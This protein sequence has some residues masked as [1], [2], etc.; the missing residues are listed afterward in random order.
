MKTRFDS[1]SKNST[2]VSRVRW[3]D[4]YFRDIGGL[5]SAK[6]TLPATLLLLATCFLGIIRARRLFGPAG[7]LILRVAEPMAIDRPFDAGD[8]V[9]AH[10]E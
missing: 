5:R 8:E 1:G 4:R 10:Q 9:A 3:T 2:E 7:R 6:R